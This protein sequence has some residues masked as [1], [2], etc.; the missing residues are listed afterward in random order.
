MLEHEP[1]KHEPTCGWL[2][3]VRCLTA[4]RLTELGE[5]RNSGA[6]GIFESEEWCTGFVTS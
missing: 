1:E 5:I 4:A 2:S 3:T 6:V